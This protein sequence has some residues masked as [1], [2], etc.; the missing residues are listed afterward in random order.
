MKKAITHVLA[1]L[2][3][4]FLILPLQEKN[5]PAIIWLLLDGLVTHK[6]YLWL[7]QSEVYQARKTHQ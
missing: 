1:R 6:H 4:V 2:L 5:E 7:T 3:N